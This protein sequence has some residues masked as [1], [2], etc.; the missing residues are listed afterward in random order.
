MKNGP[1]LLNDSS[2]KALASSAYVE[3]LVKYRNKPEYV[4]KIH[5]FMLI[6]NLRI[7]CGY[8]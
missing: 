4:E 7:D 1:W 2:N 3:A 8:H 6:N 5:E